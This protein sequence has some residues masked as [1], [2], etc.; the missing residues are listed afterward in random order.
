MR[1]ILAQFHILFFQAAFDFQQVVYLLFE[2]FLWCSQDAE[3]L[4]LN[5][6]VIL[7]QYAFLN[8]LLDLQIQIIYLEREKKQ[9]SLYNFFATTFIVMGKNNK[10]LL[11]MI[12]MFQVKWPALHVKNTQV[13]T[14]FHCNT[15]EHVYLNKNSSK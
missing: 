15:K 4:V 10:F 6:Q 5:L 1:C 7:S 11:Y 14:T 13:N 8:L 9:E 12:N 2:L 3:L